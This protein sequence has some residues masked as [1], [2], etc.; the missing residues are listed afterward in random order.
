MSCSAAL[1][2]P[3]RL[4]LLA[5]G[6]I[7][8]E[9]SHVFV[10]AGVDV[11]VLEALPQLLPR[12]DAD[13]VSVL[14]AASEDLGIK[15]STG[16]AINA[17]ERTDSGYSVT[18]EQNGETQRISTHLVVNGT[19]RVPN[20]GQLNLDAGGIAYTRGAIDIDEVSRSTSN[21]RV[22]V[23][24]DALVHTP[25]LSP[26]ATAEGADA[27]R[28][29]LDT[30][31]RN[32]IPQAVYTIPALSSV[33]LTESEAQTRYLSLKV[34]TSDMSSWFSAKTYAESTAWAKVLIDEA[35]DQIVGAHLV[36][37][38]GEELIHLFTL[39]MNHGISASQLQATTFA[40]PTFSS[41]VKNML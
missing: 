38:R 9:F 24:G 29:R 41:D 1:N 14:Q 13:A 2:Y 18:Y 34:R 4:Y 20:I 8:L 32:H 33:G 11:T 3:S 39:A 23:V 5:A 7:A 36:G 28:E 40:F 12:M 31:Q 27:L 37:H 15:F 21:P 6:V 17:I 16:V 30:E 19:G 25:Q 26:V 35:T 10:R 22:R